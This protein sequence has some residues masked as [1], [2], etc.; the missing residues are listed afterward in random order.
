LRI[1]NS[2]LTRNAAKIRNR[3][4]NSA[5]IVADKTDLS[6]MEILDAENWAKS[7]LGVKEADSLWSTQMGITFMLF[8][9]YDKSL[10]Q[11]RKARQFDS[12]NWRAGFCI[13]Q[14]YARQK[15]YEQA[16]EE[17]EKIIRAFRSSDELMQN[18]REY[19][20][21]HLLQCL[22]DWN[23]ALQRYDAAF[24]AFQEAFEANHSDY[25]TALKI[26]VLLKKQEKIRELF[27]FLDRMNG[28]MDDHGLTRLIAMYHQHSDNPAHHDTISFTAQSL[29]KLDV[30]KNLY[31]S[32]I[33]A[34]T[35]NSSK[36]MVL[37]ALRHWYGLT[38]FYYCKSEEDRKAAIEVL[39]KNT[40]MFSTNWNVRYVCSRTAKTLAFVYLEQA[41]CAG[42][43]SDAAEE[44]LKKL[45]NLSNRDSAELDIT[46]LLGRLHLLRDNEDEARACLKDYAKIA[47]DLLSDDDPDNDWQGYLKLAETLSAFGD[48]KNAIAAWCLIGPTEAVSATDITDSQKETQKNIEPSGERAEGTKLNHSDKCRADYKNADATNDTVSKKAT[49]ITADTPEASDGSELKANLYDGKLEAS[50]YPTPDKAATEDQPPS[51]PM[52]VPRPKDGP[53][54]NYCDGNC[55]HTWSIADN[56]YACKDCIDVQFEPSCFEKLRRGALDQMIC[57]RDH[58][59]LHVPKFDEEA[60]AKIPKGMLRVG[61]DLISVKDWLNDIRKK[62]GI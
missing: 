23:S 48:D 40:A 57:G 44:Y 18:H 58:E 36:L 30:I 60:W 22:A 12:Q 38:L 50:V 47:L 24:E 55:G 54:G 41:K 31:Q 25:D 1:T 28:E 7:E 62:M 17:V 5:R 20:L 61:A 32:A 4:D 14:T 16:I 43:K 9:L 52:D 6:L 3:K 49:D 45:L 39:E 21:T 53:L 29:N 34:A 35:G 11:C 2:K 26:I 19:F 27:D 10:E 51:A 46:L 56:I 59:F 33:E 8:E 37:V 13:A 42:L 15:S